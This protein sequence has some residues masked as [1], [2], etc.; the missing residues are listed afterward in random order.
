MQILKKNNIALLIFFL[1]VGFFLRYIN[2][3]D[4]MYWLDEAY[5]LYLSDPSIPL[6]ELTKKI[7]DI[8]DNPAI[9]FYL[10]S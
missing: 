10:V 1:I 3:F 2:N 4:Q 5:T 6:K 8:D 9:Y 7:Y